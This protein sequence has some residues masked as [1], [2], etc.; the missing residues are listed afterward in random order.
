MFEL[1]MVLDWIMH[2]IFAYL[3]FIRLL[4]IKP[5]MAEMS[6]IELKTYIITAVIAFLIPLS[7]WHISYSFVGTI[8]Y[9]FFGLVNVIL[10]DV[11]YFSTQIILNLFIYFFPAVKSSAVLFTKDL[12]STVSVLVPLL[13]FSTSSYL[14]FDFDFAEEHFI[15]FIALV[16]GFTVGLVWFLVS[17]KRIKAKDK[18]VEEYLNNR[19][20]TIGLS[21]VG[22]ARLFVTVLY[23]FENKKRGDSIVIEYI[24]EMLAINERK[25]ADAIESSM[26]SAL[27]TAWDKAGIVGKSLEKQCPADPDRG[28]PSV[29]G[30]VEHFVERLRQL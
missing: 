10:R 17:L 28:Y 27:K 20:Q 21:G 16:A 3:F 18:S 25:T 11:A 19:F 2:A 1:F 8:I 6:K 29:K 7:V 22:R 30:F 9:I 13:A 26:R 5:T 14:A 12:K 4:G 15:L 23:C 24:C